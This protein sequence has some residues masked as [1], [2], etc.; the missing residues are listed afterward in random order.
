[1]AKLIYEHN[2]GTQ[3]TFDIDPDLIKDLDAPVNKIALE[4]IL[5]TFQA[6]V[7]HGN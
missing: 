5:K 3:V 2:D 6:E 1:M 4:Q 7:L